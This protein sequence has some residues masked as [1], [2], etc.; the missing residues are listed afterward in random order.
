[1]KCLIYLADDDINMLNLLSVFL[2]QHEF[3]VE[4]FTDGESLLARCRETLPD[5]VIL[6]IMMP[7]MDGLSVLS[8]IRQS[9]GDLPVIIISARDSSYD[10]LAGLTL[11]C[12]DYIAKPF[13]PLE[14]V[15][16]ARS[17]LKA[18]KPEQA[19]T[20]SADE[21]ELVFGPLSLSPAKRTATH[22]GKPFPLTPTEFDFLAFLIN[23]KGAAVSREELLSTLWEVNWESDSRAADDL[24]KRL[25]RKLRLLQSPVKIKTAWG[26][27]FRIAL[28][29]NNNEGND[30]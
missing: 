30:A 7:G 22:D 16:R 10:R 11:G 25:R 15:I 28:E 6:D 9:Y 18:S 1:M 24:V 5:L 3:T 20:D 17:V 13:L 14:L 21:T 19:R 12:D 2:T 4:A 29:D 26:Y 23:R 8:A 27:G